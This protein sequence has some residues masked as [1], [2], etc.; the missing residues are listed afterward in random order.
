MSESVR[1]L[2]FRGR[3]S[4]NKVSVGEPAE[5]SLAP[6]Y[7][8]AGFA[9]GT[10]ARPPRSRVPRTERN[11][12]E[13]KGALFA[14]GGGDRL[15]SFAPGASSVRDARREPPTRGSATRERKLPPR[16]RGGRRRGASALRAASREN[17]RPRDRFGGP[18]ATPRPDA[19][20]GPSVT[21]EKRGPSLRPARRGGGG[22]RK[23]KKNDSLR[24]TP[25]VSRR[26]RTQRGAISDVKCGM[27]RIV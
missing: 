19:A 9:L 2:P 14:S 24:W 25:R 15:R 21:I 4:R 8:R 6:I 7:V 16:P 13:T 10:A 18:T 26:R 5:G 20:L 22:P 11:E 1:T 17:H 27:L 12:T 23:R 3:R